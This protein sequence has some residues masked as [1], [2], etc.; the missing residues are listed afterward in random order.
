MGANFLAIVASG[1]RLGVPRTEEGR[2]G[3]STAWDRDELLSLSLAISLA[4]AIGGWL[5]VL[6]TWG[7]STLVGPIGIVAA[8]PGFWSRRKR[9]AAIAL[10][11]NSALSVVLVFWLT[12][13][14]D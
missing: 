12:G 3:R 2:A 11:L 1:R 10:V 4:C 7:F 9:L 5:S 8:L 6:S 13:S 14:L